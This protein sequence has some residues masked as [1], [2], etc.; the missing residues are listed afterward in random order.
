MER[1]YSSILKNSVRQAWLLVL[2]SLSPK[3]NISVGEKK[4]KRNTKN[5]EAN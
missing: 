3:P 2:F 5:R 4:K 1:G